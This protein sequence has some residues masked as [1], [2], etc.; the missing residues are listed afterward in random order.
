M[1]NDTPLQELVHRALLALTY[2]VF[3]HVGRSKCLVRVMR[4]LKPLH[5]VTD[6]NT[7]KKET[8]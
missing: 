3:F 7:N 4:S 5:P 6:R 1:M 2:F 8:H